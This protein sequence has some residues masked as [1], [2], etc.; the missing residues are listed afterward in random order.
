VPVN[1]AEIAQAIRY[2]AGSP[3]SLA[4]QAPSTVVMEYWTGPKPDQRSLHLLNSVDRPTGKAVK[5]TVPLKG[6]KGKLSVEL[7]SPEWPKGKPAR[8]TYRGGLASFG[9]P[10]FKLY[11]A[12]VVSFPS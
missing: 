9:V 10:S 11:A 6:P 5:V 3:L 4:V 7:L 1:W 2:A 8:V 12:A